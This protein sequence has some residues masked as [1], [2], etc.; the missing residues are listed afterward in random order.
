MAPTIKVCP[1][2]SL[3]PAALTRVEYDRVAGT[4]LG[5][6]EREKRVKQKG[7]ERMKRVNNLVQAKGTMHVYA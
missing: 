7:N 1:A 4:E 6:R 3:V 5:A 2:L